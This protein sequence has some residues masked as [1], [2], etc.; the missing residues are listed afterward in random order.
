MY[1]VTCRR[2][3]AW[4]DGDRELYR[5]DADRWRFLDS[6]AARVESYGTVLHQYVLM[7]NHFHLVLETP[8]GNCSAFMQSLL[9]SYTVYF[10]L[11]H[12]RHGHLFDGRFKAKLVEGDDYLLGLSRYVHLNPVRVAGVEDDPKEALKLLC[13]YYWSSYLQYIGRRKRLDFVTYATTLAQMHGR[14]KD[15]PARYRKF[16]E[17]GVSEADEELDAAMEISRLGIGGE[18]FRDQ[19]QGLYATLVSRVSHPEDTALRREVRTLPV[20]QVLAQLAEEMDCDQGDFLIRQKGTPL[21]PFA[22]H[23]LTHYAGLSQRV[24]ADVLAVSTG[25]AVCL[26][27]RRFEEL[28]AGHKPTRRLADQCRTALDA[29]FRMLDATKT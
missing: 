4:R 20:E 24:V 10:N 29:S 22:A 27:L 21:R 6:L 14:V 12:G 11:R 8:R 18:A 26:Q 5:D 3:G 9:T 19:M 7:A 2:V 16:V 1:H 17:A 25:A 13:N 23:F 15:R 28:V